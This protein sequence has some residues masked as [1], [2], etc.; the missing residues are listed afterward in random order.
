M[1]CWPPVRGTLRIWPLLNTL[2]RPH[3]AQYGRFA[4]HNPWKLF[5]RAVP[6][7]EKPAVPQM[8]ERASL[9]LSLRP[10][11]RRAKKQGNPCEAPPPMP[12]E[13]EA[14]PPPQDHKTNYRDANQR[15]DHRR[16]QRHRARPGIFS[17]RRPRTS[18]TSLLSPGIC[19]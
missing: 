19:M 18:S 14:T 17:S 12:S 10:L 5:A 3:Q 2:F 7:S 11:L 15:C 8:E 16:Y 9:C 6:Q 4:Q 1:T 13:Q